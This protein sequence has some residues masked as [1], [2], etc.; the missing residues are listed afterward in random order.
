MADQGQDC[1]QPLDYRNIGPT[2]AWR[3]TSISYQMYERM[4]SETLSPWKAMPVF[5]FLLISHDWMHHVYLGT[6]RDLCGSGPFF[7]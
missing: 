3:L 7:P 1:P 6:A 4:D 5:H 2:S